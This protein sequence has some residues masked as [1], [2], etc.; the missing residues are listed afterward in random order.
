MKNDMKKTSAHKAS[1]RIR[2]KKSEDLSQNKENSVIE[3]LTTDH[4]S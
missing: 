2:N 3:L 1:N 4:G